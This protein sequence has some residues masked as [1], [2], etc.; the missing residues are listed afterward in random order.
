MKFEIKSRYDGRVL[1]SLETESLRSCVE[2][3]VKSG[4]RL[5]GAYFGGAD[6]GRAD[7]RGARFGGAY[8]GGAYFGGAYLG[9]AYLGGADL[10]GAY[11]GGAKL[12]TKCGKNLLLV[13]NRPVL[14]VGLLGS[15]ADYLVAFLTDNG[16]YIRTGCFFDTLQA[17]ALA[18]VK[19]HGE[20]VHAAEYNAAVGLI[21]CHAKH[22]T[23][24]VGSDSVPAAGEAK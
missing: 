16:V 15:R 20:N 5:S 7:L 24:S 13:G 19:E 17:F 12:K 18:V 21:E 8:F 23:P 14:Q 1:F 11:L 4:A 9:G 6:L 2:A 3:A 10:G 22:W